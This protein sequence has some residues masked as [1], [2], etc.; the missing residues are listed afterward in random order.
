LPFRKRDQR[1][2]GRT[3]LKTRALSPGGYNEVLNNGMVD[4]YL[5]PILRRYAEYTLTSFAGALQ[6]ISLLSLL[7]EYTLAANQAL[8]V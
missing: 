2:L 8:P 1:Q 6:T 3:G 5:S 7:K 4:A